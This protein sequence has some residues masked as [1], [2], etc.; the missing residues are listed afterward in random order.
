M[1]SKAFVY[2]ELSDFNFEVLMLRYWNAHPNF[3]NKIHSICFRTVSSALTQD[4]RITVSYLQKVLH[5]TKG[6]VQVQS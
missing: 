1:Q 2:S 3:L 5:T 6:K 4:L